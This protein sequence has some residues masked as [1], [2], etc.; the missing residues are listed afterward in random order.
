[1]FRRPDITGRTLRVGLALAAL[2]V[3]PVAAEAQMGGQRGGGRGGGMPMEGVQRQYEMVRDF[4]LQTARGVPASVLAYRPTDEVRSFG[5]LLGHVANASYSF[6]S[7]ALGEASP[8]STNY[9]EVTDKAG[10]TRGL[11]EAFAYCDR[12]HTEIAGPRMMEQ[13]DLFGQSGSRLWVLTFNATHTW[14]H[15]GNLVT[16]M[17]LNGLVPPSSGGMTGN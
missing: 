13:V 11:E 12:A 3:F 16:Y 9:E 10:L 7:T 5:E 4:I 8:S 14:E 17:R 1:M 2:S 15:Y 6:C